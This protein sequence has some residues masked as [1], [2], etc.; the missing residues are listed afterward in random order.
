MLNKFRQ[1][2]VQYITTMLT[3]GAAMGII[4][5]PL[6]AWFGLCCTLA[7][8]FFATGMWFVSIVLDTLEARR[9]GKEPKEAP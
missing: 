6:D 5:L 9:Q 8:I 2:D 3:A 7:G 1:N 4:F